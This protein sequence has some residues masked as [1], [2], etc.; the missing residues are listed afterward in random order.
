[1]APGSSTTETNGAHISIRSQCSEFKSQITEANSGGEV[2]VGGETTRFSICLDEA[3][4]P[5][6]HLS[7]TG[8]PFGYISNLSVAGPDS[9]PIGYEVTAGG[10]CTVRNGNFAVKIVTFG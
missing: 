8:C 3:T 9:Y 2:Q 6:S 4:H 7:T 10:S 5:L 1:L